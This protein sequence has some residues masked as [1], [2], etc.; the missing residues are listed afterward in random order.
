MISSWLTDIRD[1]F[2]ELKS[3]RNRV[4]QLLSDVAYM[5]HYVFNKK[6]TQAQKTKPEHEWGAV[7]IEPLIDR[8]VFAAVA[9]KR[10]DRS[11]VTP[12]RVVSIPT[13]LTGL[14]GC[15]NCGAGMTT[16]RAAT[17]RPHHPEEQRPP[18][19]Q[20]RWAS[21]ALPPCPARR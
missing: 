14:L 11:A 9:A 8:Q 6:D 5:G 18:V 7:S 15:G 10:H 1:G 20:R 4:Q 16:A 12:A 13:L 2:G 21:R 17:W 3:G 19:C